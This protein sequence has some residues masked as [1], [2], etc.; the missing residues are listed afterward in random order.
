MLLFWW[1]IISLFQLENEIANSFNYSYTNAYVERTN[2]KLKLMK[3]IS[4]G[5]TN[6]ERIKKSLMMIF[7]KL[8]ILESSLQEAI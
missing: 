8:D 1:S 2:Q 7:G 5:Y 4:Y 3:R 6:L